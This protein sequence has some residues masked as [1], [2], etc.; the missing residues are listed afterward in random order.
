MKNKVIKVAFVIA[1]S[2]LVF[3]P[4]HSFSESLTPEAT[5]ESFLGAIRAMEFPVKDAANHSQLV[6]RTM[7]RRPATRPKRS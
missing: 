5:I 6:S 7:A 4:K 1:I 3:F 2:V